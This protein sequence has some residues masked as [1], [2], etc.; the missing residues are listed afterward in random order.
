M[1]TER[2]QALF[3]SSF[4]PQSVCLTSL[5]LPKLFKDRSPR[6]ME[7]MRNTSKTAFKA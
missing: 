2:R 3:S 7:K 1:L 4:P 6:L 5:N